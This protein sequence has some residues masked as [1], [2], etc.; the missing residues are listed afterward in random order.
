MRTP[1]LPKLQSL[2]PSEAQVQDALIQG[3]QRRGWLVVRVNSGAFKMPHGGF[4]RAYLVA[5][6]CDA[7]GRPACSGFPDVLALRAAPDGSG[8]VARLFELKAKG[9]ELGEAQ[10]RFRDFALARGVVVEVVEGWPEM[11]AAVGRA[12]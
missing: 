8:I 6:L 11:E 9:G 3:L 5:G 1:R 7:K 2:E 10:E 12:A 4:F